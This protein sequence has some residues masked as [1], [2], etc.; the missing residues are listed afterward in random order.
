VEGGAPDVVI[1]VRD[2][3]IGI[4]ADQ[5]PRI[6]EMFGQVDSSLERSEGGLGIGLTLVKTLTELHGGTVEADSAGLGQGSELV[7]RLPIV[8]AAPE[9]P[10]FST[11]GEPKAAAARRILVVDDNQDSAES[12]AM[13]LQLSGHETQTAHDGLQA[14]EMAVSFRP[15][16]VLLDLGLPKL[17]GYDAARRIRE[18]RRDPGLVIVA[19]TGW[20]QEHDRRR[21]REAGIDFHLV[22]PVEYG[23]VVTLLAELPVDRGSV[24]D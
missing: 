12:L 11:S 9:P 7:V 5:L 22:K 6:F 18:Q 14:V 13:L 19:L 4:A 20:G 17:N 16:V 3:G 8:V 23:T 24:G 15:D 21:S 10:A 1:R 2:R